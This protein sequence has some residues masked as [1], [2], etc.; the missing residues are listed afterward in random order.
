MKLYASCTSPTL[1]RLAADH[2]EHRFA[3]GG[4]DHMSTQGRQALMASVDGKV[5]L[6]TAALMRARV[7]NL[8]FTL[9]VEDAPPWLVLMKRAFSL[10]NAAPYPIGWVR[11]Y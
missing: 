8:G 2:I 10:F 7:Q 5:F 9:G 11:N 6:T 4:V 3:Q 1:C